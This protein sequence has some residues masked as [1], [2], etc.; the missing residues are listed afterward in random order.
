M[1]VNSASS[2]L[3]ISTPGFA[4]DEE[5]PARLLLPPPPRSLV[6]AGL[7]SP[8]AMRPVKPGPGSGNAG[9]QHARCCWSPL[10][11]LVWPNNSCLYGAGISCDDRNPKGQGVFSGRPTTR[12]QG[13]VRSGSPQGLRTRG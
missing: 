6:P 13:P 11:L 4:A 10:A 5:L 9:A 2:A 12:T 3:V 7:A 8:C 1:S